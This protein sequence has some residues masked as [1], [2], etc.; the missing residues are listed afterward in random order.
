LG[1]NIEQ[2]LVS[3]KNPLGFTL[4]GNIGELGEFPFLHAWLDPVV[5]DFSGI[6]SVNSFGVRRML[7]WME[8]WEPKTVRYANCPE[9]MLDAFT[10]IPQMLKHK[11]AQIQIVSIMARL[12]CMN[13]GALRTASVRDRD[14][15]QGRVGLHLKNTH[16]ISCGGTMD[17]TAL[18]DIALFVNTGAIVTGSRG[19]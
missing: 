9:V 19:S 13:C 3:K 7:K 16:C 4:S 15:E 14:I 8:T 1:E 2:M 6:K 12:E 11:K 17:C 10:M 18:A 5:L